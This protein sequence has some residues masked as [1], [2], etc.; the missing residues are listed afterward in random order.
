[1]VE[2]RV[3]RPSALLNAG[4]DEGN[5]DTGDNPARGCVSTRV[6][7]K[8]MQQQNGH[9]VWNIVVDDVTEVFV[10]SHPA[11]IK[12]ELGD[13]EAEAPTAPPGEEGSKKGRPQASGTPRLQLSTP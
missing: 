4:S 13:G 3:Q 12:K 9:H 2:V 8:G 6:D 10:G 11:Q 1:M 5:H 7:P